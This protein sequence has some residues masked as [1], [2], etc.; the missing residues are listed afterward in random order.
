[1]ISVNVY[2]SP[3][4]NVTMIATKAIGVAARTGVEVCLSH[5]G[6]TII[7][8]LDDRSDDVV[9][10]LSGRAAKDEC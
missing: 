10:R 1:M 5:N 7:V 3:D 6:R 8:D 2:A 9:A 4:E